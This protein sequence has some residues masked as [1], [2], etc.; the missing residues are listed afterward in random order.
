MLRWS[1]AQ[2]LPAHLEEL[3]EQIG[4]LRDNWF[5]R[6]SGCVLVY[7]PPHWLISTGRL[8]HAA[9]L[10]SYQLTLDATG[11]NQASAV[12]GERLLSCSADQL[13]G[14]QGDGPL[15]GSAPLA[16]PPPLVGAMTALILETE[17][18]LAELYHKLE[19]A[20]THGICEADPPYT[21]LLRGYSATTL[22]QNWNQLIRA[23]ESSKRKTAPLAQQDLDRERETIQ[24]HIQVLNHERVILQR[25]MDSQSMKISWLRSMNE[26]CLLL[27]RDHAQLSRRIRGLTSRLLH[28]TAQSESLPAQDG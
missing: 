17:P 7:M 3:L 24:R 13:A 8:P 19:R 10:A 11:I 1:S 4:A 25:R 22:V 16:A 9:I 27:L 28:A 18:K 20:S 15:P 2:P 21:A 23:S 5:S 26:Q 14:W 6:E 12:N